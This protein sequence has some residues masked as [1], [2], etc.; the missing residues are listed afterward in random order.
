MKALCHHD[1]KGS[2]QIKTGP[3]ARR[4]QKLAG[5][6]GIPFRFGKNAKAE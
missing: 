5:W 4:T 2:R 6:L 1:T 3:V